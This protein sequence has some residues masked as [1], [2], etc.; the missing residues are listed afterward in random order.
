MYDGFS[1]VHQF[2]VILQNALGYKRQ[3]YAAKTPN[4]IG[5]HHFVLRAVGKVSHHNVNAQRA[6]C[7]QVGSNCIKPIGLPTYEHHGHTA[8]GVA[9]GNMF[10]NRRR[11]GK[12]NVSTRC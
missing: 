4:H 10:G 2:V 12:V 6:S 9:T 11:S 7:F 1:I 3:F 5:N 8:F